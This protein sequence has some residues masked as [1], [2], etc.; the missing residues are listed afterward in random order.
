LHIYE[1][2]LAA[3]PPGVPR[4]YS[5]ENMTRH[6]PCTPR[7]LEMLRGW[8]KP[9]APA[10]KIINVHLTDGARFD[11]AS[12]YSFWVYGEEPGE[13][14]YGAYA[15]VIRC[16]FPARWAV[17]K[18]AE[19]LAF[20]VDACEHLP[21]QSG[22]AG[23]VLETNEYQRQPSH[24][25]AW[26]LSMQHPGL[27]IANFLTDALALQREAIKGVNWLTMLG[28]DFAGHIGGVA[29][30]RHKLPDAIG[31]I[32]AGEGVILRAGPAP[33]SGDVNREDRLPEYRAVYKL[34]APLQDP[35]VQRYTAFSLPG[36]DHKEKTTAWLRR[37]ADAR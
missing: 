12:E 10:R 5:T 16:A 13:S 20:A 24:T 22:H 26:R 34:V 21:F 35:I 27:D 7:A 32:P 15:N 14:T 8:L 6:K 3:C 36:G 23:F 9:G 29:A 4:W 18:P 28:A 11:D 25:A 33:R 19:L 30:M 31:I 37:F 2:F 1:K 17:E